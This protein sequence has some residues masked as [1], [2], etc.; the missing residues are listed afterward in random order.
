MKT[1]CLS[2]MIS[3][4][5]AK[6][7]MLRSQLVALTLTSSVV[8]HRAMLYEQSCIHT[9]ANITYRQQ[10]TNGDKLNIVPYDKQR[11]VARLEGRSLQT[12][13]YTL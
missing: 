13:D 10:T 7:T 12:G 6:S 11:S 4:Q 8:W 1:F 3:K 9:I 5:E 2:G